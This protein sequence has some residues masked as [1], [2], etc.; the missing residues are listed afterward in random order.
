MST[1][2]LLQQLRAADITLSV[3]EGR[4]SVSAPRGRLTPELRAALTA[5]KAA[6]IALLED[7]ASAQAATSKPLER[8]DRSQPPPLS[9][10]Q[11]RIWFLEELEGG[12]AVYNIPWA[13]RIRGPLQPAA[14]EQA[15]LELQQR[16]ESLRT[17]FADT[18]AGPRQQINAGGNLSIER[19]RLPAASDAEIRQQVSAWATREFDLRTGPLLHAGLIES[20]RDDWVL[21]LV[22]HHIVMDGWSLEIL[23]RELFALYSSQ[24]TN[25]VT[26][27]PELPLQL[28]DYAAWQREQIAAGAFDSQIRYWKRQLAGAPALLSLPTDR[29]RPAEQSYRGARLQRVLPADL[30]RDLLEFASERGVTLFMLL[31]AT[32]KVLL[33]RCSGQA[34]I[35][36]GTPIAGRQRSELEGLIGLF[37]NTLALRSDLGSDPAFGELLSGVQACCLDGYANQ[38]MPFDRVLEAIDTPRNLSHTP[39]FQVQFV[40]QNAPRDGNAAGGL[41]FA[42]VDFDYGTA[43]FDLTL[44]VAETPTGLATE[45]EYCSDLFL[46]ETI[47]QLAHSFEVL[48]RAVITHPE[49]PVSRLPLMTPAD[50]SATLARLRGPN[51]SYDLD[52]TVHGLFEQQVRLSPTV[53]ALV[54]D[55]E[56]LSYAELNERA[57]QLANWLRQQGNGAGTH[58]GVYL[59]R[60]T[61]MVVSL[62]A[63]LK[64]GAAYVPLDP[65]YPAQRLR[66][67]LDDADIGLVLSASALADELPEHPA[68]IVLLD[69]MTAEL[70]AQP[71]INPS[72]AAGAADL[73]Y[74][75]FT[76][77][78]TGR[79]KGV[80]NTHQGICNRLLWMQDEY[81]LATGDR[82]LQKTPFSF[83]VSVWE[84]FWPLQTGATL[85]VAKPDGHKDTGYLCRTIQAHNITTLHFV[86]TM[87]QVFLD[88]PQVSL[89]GSLRRVICSGEVLPHD[90][91]TRFYLT[92]DAE[93]HNLY[94]PTEAA[95][96]VTHWSC[97][98]DSRDA[99]VPIGR[100]VAN[101]PLYIVEANGE[102]APPGVAGELW[103]GGVQ[104]ARGYAGRPDLTAERFIPDPFAVD[105]ANRVYRTGDRARLRHDDALEFLGRIDQQVKLRGLRI[106]P[107]EIEAALDTL[108]GVRQSVVLLRADGANSPQLVAYLAAAGHRPAAGE[109]RTALAAVLP[110]YMV[111]AAFVW[112]DTFPLLPNGKVDRSSLPAPDVQPAAT[113]DYT[114]PATPAEITLA[115]IWSEL[116]RVER[117]GVHDNFFELGGD[118]ILS[119]QIITRA[120]RAGLRLQPKQLFRYQTIAELA[121][122]AE[123]APVTVSEQAAVTGTVPLTPVQMW[124]LN[125]EAT[126]RHHFN[127]SIR[128]TV[129]QPL[130]ADVAASALAAIVRHHDALRLEFDCDGGVWTQS[131]GDVTRRPPVEVLQV[132]A[133][134][135]A[136]QEAEI[137]AAANAAQAGFDIA[138]GPLL[139]A[140][141]IARGTQLSELIIVVHHL[142]MDGLSWR[143]LLED[144]STACNQLSAGQTP[145]LPPKTCSLQDWSG[146]LRDYADS[147]ELRAE[148]RYWREQ[149]WDRCAAV[150]V[151][152]PDGANRV[153]TTATA[154]VRLSAAQTDKLLTQTS[155]AFRTQINDLLLAAF[156]RAW[157]RWCGQPQV[158]LDLEGHGREVVLEDIDISRTVGWFTTLYPVAL[159]A[160]HSAWDTLLK[161]TKEHLRAIP[162]NGLGCGVLRYLTDVD[163]S[164]VPRAQVLFNYLGQF[165]QSFSADGLFGMAAGTRGYEQSP[166]RERSHLLEVN[167]GVYGGELQINVNYSHEQH[168]AA[169]AE[170][171]ASHYQQALEELIDYCADPQH[172][173]ATPADFPLAR[174]TQT[175][176][177]KLLQNYPDATDIYPVTALQH[178]MLFQSQLSDAGTQRF[179]DVYLTQVV[180]TLAGRLDTAAFEAAWQEVTARHAS[181]RTAFALSSSS[182]PLAVVCDRAR[183]KLH[184]ADWQS[185]DS[186]AQDAAL[187]ALLEEDRRRSFSFGDAPLMRLY[188]GRCAA[189][190]QRF[191]WSHHHI[192]MDGWSIPVVLAEVFAVYA[193]LTRDR[194]PQLPPAHD[195]RN[196]IEWLQEQDPTAAETHWREVLSDFTR[197]TPLPGAHLPAAESAAPS[198]AKHFQT[199]DAPATAQLRD[200][201]RQLRVTLNSL[202]Q[203]VWALVLSRYSGETDILFGA[204][205]SGRPAALPH[206]DQM[207]GLFLNTLPCRIKVDGAREVSHWLT[208][209]QTAQLAARQHEHTALTDLQSWSG[210]GRG[211]ELF[212]TLLVFENYPDAE[213]LITDRDELRIVD[214]QARGWTSF[215]LSVA[216]S[217]GE[218]LVLRIAYDTRLFSAARIK[219]MGEY[220]CQMLRAVAEQPTATVAS[221]LELSPPPCPA[222]EVAGRARPEPTGDPAGHASPVELFEEQVTARPAAAAIAGWEDAQPAAAWSYAEL[223]AHA[224]RIAHQLLALELPPGSRVGLLQ[225]HDALMIAA[226][227]GT[228]KAGHAY[229]PLDPQSPHARL[230]QIAADMD[231]ATVVH[232]PQHAA[233]AAALAAAP[234]EVSVTATTKAATN[235]GIEVPDEALAYILTTSGS[236]GRPKGVMQTRRNMTRL[237]L[238]YAGAIGITVADRLSLF[239]TYGFDA[240][241]M[242][243]FGALLTG[244]T[245]CPVDIRR[246]ESA[247][248]VQTAVNRLAVSVVHATPTVYRYLF[249]TAPDAQLP[250][251]RAVVLGGEPARPVDLQNFKRCFKRGAVFVNGLGLTESTLALQY[252]ADHDT[253][254]PA[255][256]LPVGTA[257]ADTE[258]L[259]LDAAQRPTV[260]SGEIGIHSPWL[261]P[262]Y[263]NA[264]E[265]TAAAFFTDARGRRIYRT[266]DLARVN[267]DGALVYCGRRDAQLKVRG[268]RIEPGEITFA[269][270]SA[271][272][273]SDSAV[274]LLEDTGGIMRLTAYVVPATGCT[275]D[276][277]ALRA[278]LTARLPDY[279]VPAAFVALEALPLTPNGKLDTRR[280]PQ[281]GLATAAA[282]YVPP[283][284]ELEVAMAGIWSSV[285]GVDRVGITDNFFALGGHSLNATQLVARLRETLDI[286][287]SLRTLFDQ[288]T[289][290]SLINH[291]T[292]APAPARAP[293]LPR[294]ADA[295]IPLALPQ[296]RLWFIEQLE[297]GSSVYVLSW[298]IRVSDP[299]SA[300]AL[301]TAV[302][303]LLARHESLRTRFGTAA[304]GP[305]QIVE[306][307]LELPI[308]HCRLDADATQ[309]LGRTLAAI[310]H[311][312]F[313]LSTAPLFRVHLLE[314]SPDERVLAFSIHHIMADNW[315][316]QILMR[317]L[318]T[319]YEAALNGSQPELPELPL[320][321]GDYA[322]WQH[323]QQTADELQR[324]SAYWLAQLAGAS[325]VLELPADRPRPATPTHEGDQVHWVLADHTAASLRAVA[326]EAG[327]SP[328]MTLIAVYALLLSRYSGANDLLIGTPIAGRPHSRLENLIGFFVN[329]LTIRADLSGNPSFN[330]LL[331]RTRTTTLDA[332]AHQDLPFEKLIEALQPERDMSRS[333]VFQ[334]AFILQ[335]APTPGAELGSRFGE[336][337]P[338]THANSKFDM[339]L[340]M[341]ETA[342]AL[343]GSFEFNTDIFDRSTI[344]R[345]SEHFCTL[346]R[347]T[348]ENPGVPLAE[349]DMLPPPERR[350]VLVDWNTTRRDYAGG[351]IQQRFAE[352]VRLHPQQ[353]ALTCDGHTL[354]YAELDRR[355]NRLAHFLLASGVRSETPVALCL[356]RSLDAVVS[357]LAIIKA[358]GA[359]VPLDPTYP[360]QRLEFMLTDTAS[361]VLLTHAALV[362]NLGGHACTRINLDQAAAEIAQC[363]DSDPPT[364]ASGEQLAYIV[365]TSGSTG[366]PKGVLIEQ[367]SVLALVVNSDFAPLERGLR[368]GMLAPIS[369]DASTME[370]W[371]ALLNGGECVVFPDRVPELSSLRRFFAAHPLDLLFLTTGLFNTIIDAGP[372]MLSNVSQL[373]TGG[374]AMSADHVRRARA[375]LPDIQLANI[376]G[377]TESTTYATVFPLPDELPDR[378][379]IPI[380]R[381]L[382]NTKVYILDAAGQP[383]AVGAPGELY[384]GGDGLA[385]GYLGQPELT[386]ERFVTN[387]FA[388]G[389]RLYRTGD[390]ARYLPDGVIEFLGRSDTQVKLRGFRIELGEIESTLREHASVGD[391][392]ATVYDVDALDRRLVAYVVPADESGLDTSELTEFLAQRLPEYMRPAG[393]QVLPRLPLNANGKVDRARLPQPEWQATQRY[394]EPRNALE[395]RLC[396][397]WQELLGVA[398][399]GIDDDFFELGGH[400]LLTIKMLERIDSEFGQKLRVAQVFAQPT[401]AAVAALLEPSASDSTGADAEATPVGTLLPI[402]TSGRRPPLFC[403]HG[404]PLKMARALDSEQPLYGIY[405]S[406]DPQF[407]MPDTVEALASLYV[408]ELRRVQPQGPYHIVGYCLGGL[409][410]F[411]MARQLQAFGETVRYL[412]LIDPTNPELTFTRREWLV[413]SFSI[414]GQRLNALRFFAGRAVSSLVSRTQYVARIVA[415]YAYELAGKEIPFLLREVR[416]TGKARASFGDYRFAQVPLAGTV[417]RPDLSA[418]E[419]AQLQRYWETKFMAGAKL[420]TV[421][422]LKDHLQFMQEP[423]HTDVSIMIDEQ[424]EQL[425]RQSGTGE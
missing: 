26:D 192:I 386:A 292:P 127:Q 124:F 290:A 425:Y 54:C 223:N 245:V 247:A 333:P 376:Y 367:R 183:I 22:I 318:L 67:M 2:E 147:P 352:Q 271:T 358:G 161:A 299:F 214:M 85:V 227:L 283:R 390:L 278:W 162:H 108:P 363:P 276:P 64:A 355:A 77:G 166:E 397:L 284:T 53:N 201:A 84:F 295:P 105:P 148:A 13:V 366:M 272:A 242:D 330:E 314:M 181:L 215:P 253:P 135:A 298:A 27:L 96:D 8:T 188:L 281:P 189:D 165:D 164:D 413:R 419:A 4:L 418:D 274:T 34:D 404:E 277:A 372:D 68:R 15:L 92:L 5:N 368:I 218:Q 111:P 104:V 1:A 350:Q 294:P 415:T 130:T 378:A 212:K 31:L 421:P 317:D 320:Q 356:E 175:G 420:I 74:I 126:G 328:F 113:A 114:P 316:V 16:H 273:V 260:L 203:G 23:Q 287:V 266:G 110:D 256:A 210:V 81:R 88:D 202:A 35:V 240:A 345:L 412:A 359:Y 243:I 198:Y 239:S 32:Y 98:R 55:S 231:L 171:L 237:V 186:S 405:F 187:E 37:L 90:L 172:G 36:V 50:R 184:I 109:L 101:T 123:P 48:L 308:E 142:V 289:I 78:S 58:I 119:I 424:L 226:V 279:M 95:V 18:P 33:A 341:W 349:L 137:I 354:S 141:L 364:L 261:T 382:A 361:P 423:F 80:M 315:S 353:P 41:T 250:R 79:P 370:I 336:P 264:P 304:S 310:A 219:Q 211:Q 66:H 258:V 20:G 144:L 216:V 347:A 388:A 49:L 346:L 136:D 47:A 332:F 179:S 322:C 44:A 25:T 394:T 76:S 208:D 65:D 29:P 306:P 139:R 230:A 174:L 407:R 28:A 94:G 91:Q 9:H 182:S 220:V 10:A 155:G 232:A 132:E 326:A 270:N 178:G 236:T 244:A 411:E 121:V 40:L 193:A 373:L 46:P 331:A 329:M 169:S 89:C 391:A 251:V 410:A 406:Y 302:N 311:Q 377:P 268:H 167:G 73:A 351:G 393:L 60:S 205:T 321:Y 177:D 374:E 401:V 158:L 199:L 149:P 17:T 200:C 324:Q 145:V 296:Q 151:D 229:V 63:T 12:S 157:Q 82:V 204:T 138:Q 150:P 262:G 325:L 312:P 146:H 408:D 305:V 195:Y 217:V 170:G 11:Q 395:S 168:T 118:S 360:L 87:L 375:Q 293:L 249:N 56:V 19:M 159:R 128:L 396:L 224:N 288:H 163:L 140:L 190:R 117:V 225:D 30:S 389:E 282:E 153:S 416:H 6:L 280:L 99:I 335:N 14:L 238:N 233:C 72:P 417:F 43:K 307:E 263:W 197:A 381:P 339:T 327:C 303:A 348:A 102:P 39:V 120:A 106:E 291:M 116:L 252:F 384:I 300:D 246:T 228:L 70:R 313:D 57:N 209:I 93:L 160:D 402:R 254:V 259:L 369:F 61:D 83:D 45:F 115:E 100:P 131:F 107:G 52:A 222:V 143:I 400:S 319:L 383:V 235:P 275:C 357:V 134:A 213:S 286:E 371:G 103:I 234:L 176:L 342:D 122:T 323:T 152:H 344:E 338:V 207:V 69:T 180:W 392:V 301:Q 196:Y 337:V 21:V 269:L 51:V 156:A 343:G 334:F 7:S 194:A 191:V 309:D 255:D 422:G 380:G 403:I 387:P 362:P 125:G 385:R 3:A 173:G 340:G 42:P 86:P 409:A 62:L 414:P 257:V 267:A 399:V 221:I 365:Y 97:P 285:L 206:V 297:P 24:I 185:L 129:N 265:Q 248:V 112:L 38:D 379:R 75:I 398:R 59:R 71:T 154:C 133:S 241:V